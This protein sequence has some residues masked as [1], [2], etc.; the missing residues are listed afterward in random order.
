[1]KA[2][3]VGQESSF[4]E[5]IVSAL[6]AAKFTVHFADNI[7]AVSQA[8]ITFVIEPFGSQ[9]GQG[10]TVMVVPF[11]SAVE[12]LRKVDTFKKNTP[13]GIVIYRGEGSATELAAQSRQII[14][15]LF[16][17]S[18]ASEFY[19]GTPVVL[20][21]VVIQPERVQ[22][23]VPAPALVVPVS[24][25]RPRRITFKKPRMAPL[26][27]VILILITVVSLPFVVLALSTGFTYASVKLASRGDYETSTALMKVSSRTSTLAT[28]LFLPLTHIPF[29]GSEFSYFYDISALVTKTNQLGIVGIDT[30]KV[31]RSVVASL[32]KYQPL[33]WNNVS[34]QLSLSLSLVYRDS[35]FLR[36]QA[37]SMFSYTQVLG[38]YSSLVDSLDDIPSFQSIV[39]HLPQLV[40]ANTKAT[41]LVL[42][43][44]NMELRPTGGFIG[45]FALLTFDQGKLVSREIHDIYDADGMI[46]G[47][48]EP[49]EPIRKYLGEASWHMRDAN[50]DP[51]FPTS[52]RRVSWFL[53]K[54]MDRKV[55]GVVA[56]DLSV[57]QS[58]LKVTGPLTIE[59]YNDTLTNENMYELIQKRVEDN[60]FPGTIQ[61]KTYLA[62]TLEQVLG[63]LGDLDTSKQIL[64]VREFGK[65]LEEGGI[66]L[67]F[68]NDAVSQSIKD[69]QWDGR[70][71]TD[72]CG[73]TCEILIQSI[74]EANVGVNKANIAVSRSIISEYSYTNG[75]LKGEVFL[76]LTHKGGYT[77]NGNESYKAYVRLL[78]PVGAKVENVRIEST[79]EFSVLSPEIKQ[80]E[81]YQ[82]AGV[83][84]TVAPGT[85][86]K[87][88]YVWYKDVS[89]GQF[90][91]VWQKQSGI[92]PMNLTLTAPGKDVY[93][94]T[95]RGVE[96]L[97]FK[98]P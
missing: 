45:S 89:P 19:L 78:T 28:S 74:N 35:S 98:L 29:V 68:E 61:K 41:Y 91:I 64:L 13:N 2:V 12:Q 8:T 39:R 4:W 76:T 42:F 70:V 27:S 94:T 38:A 82:E 44:N 51:D 71:R 59:G 40:G 23:K 14:T 25:S 22:P 46:S 37:D 97:E 81:E 58:L 55:D 31:L 67:W 63:K 65:L 36:A 43:Q 52:A 57:L 15:R 87:I 73:D 26:F 62:Q 80:R 66:Q 88:T 60:F 93:N 10:Q 30:V 9:T 11:V 3:I 90:E 54:A 96:R 21:P 1:M 56:I 53:E 77:N 17:F 34:E 32:T 16:G 83:L 79:D 18:P 5:P 6:R 48:V 85:S 86:S 92:V 7:S 24:K 49:P 47:Y 20:K 33:S 50:W 72:S 75:T 95:L 84:V 69:L